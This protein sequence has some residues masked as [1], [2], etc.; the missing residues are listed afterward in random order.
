MTTYHLH[1][2]LYSK[3]QHSRHARSNSAAHTIGFLMCI[4]MLIWGTAGAAQ[5]SEN[6]VETA[7]KESGITST[8]TVAVSAENT[9]EDQ[10]LAGD[11]TDAAEP[12]AEAETRPDEPVPDQAPLRR[13]G[14]LTS[15]IERFTPTEEISAD[16]A[17]PFP[18]DI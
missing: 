2:S 12:V 3:Q 9:A 4:C 5:P 15:A 7:S 11:D 17:V 10:K 14:R 18:V 8:Q 13:P 16:N 1:L 6:P